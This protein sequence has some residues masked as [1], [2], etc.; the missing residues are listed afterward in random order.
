MNFNIIRVALE[1]AATQAAG[2]AVLILEDL[3][4]LEARAAEEEVAPLEG[5]AFQVI[6]AIRYY[7]S[8]N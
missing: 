1:A 3:S 2:G 6:R 8:Y 4:I 7:Y 5:E